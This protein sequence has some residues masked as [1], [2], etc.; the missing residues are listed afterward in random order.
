MPP[1]NHRSQNI[2]ESVP[3]TN[4]SFKQTFSSLR[5]TNFMYLWLGMLAMMSGMHMQMVARG[6]LVYEITNSA[7]ILGL[8]SAASSV[9]ILVLSLVGGEIADRMN[10]KKVMMLSQ[11]LNSLTAILVSVAIFTNTVEWYH[12]LAASVFQGATWAFLMPARQA[13]IPSLVGQSQLSNAIALNAAGMSATT[14]IAPTIA[15][16][17]YSVLGSGFVY[18]VIGVLT[19]VASVLTSMVKVEE[20]E[21]KAAKKAMTS[22]IGEGISYV[23]HNR[24]VLVLIVIGLATSLLAMP[25]RFL[26]PVLVVDI[27]RMGPESLGLLLSF[28]GIGSLAGTLYIAWVGKWHRGGTLILGTLAS[29]IAL[30]LLAILP[31]YA[32]A[33][34]IMLLLGLGDAARRALNTALIMEATDDEYR[35]RV[36]SIFMMNFGFMPL[37]ILPIGIMADAVGGQASVGLLGILIVLFTVFIFATQKQLRGIQ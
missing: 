20:P 16:I 23:M 14:L 36:M 33:V 15:G 6:Y 29:G 30:I 4:R 32:A 10:R 17:L 12:L 21:T 9:P 13:L 11:L 26:M 7:S 19:I 22:N 27:Y 37:G 34:G 5:S 8:V 31:F 1:A 28:M 25:I 3:D 35:G 2:T 24:L 18:A